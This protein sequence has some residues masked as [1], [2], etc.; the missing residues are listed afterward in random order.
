MTRLVGRR[1]V[2]LM[3]I[4]IAALA[5]AC[6]VPDP[7][8]SPTPESAEPTAAPP[9]VMWWFGSS[10]AYD[11]ATWS[12]QGYLEPNGDPTTV[13]VEVGTGTIDAP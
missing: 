7:T 10:W 13:V 11:G 5:V 6:A 2:A 4:A 12:T 1:I 3:A 8:P 9:T